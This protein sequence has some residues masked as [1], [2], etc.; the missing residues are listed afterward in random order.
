M[1][2]KAIAL[3]RFQNRSV[4][5]IWRQLAASL[6]EEGIKSHGSLGQNWLPGTYLET[7]HRHSSTGEIPKG[8]I[9]SGSS[10]SG[11]STYYVNITK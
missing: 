2:S 9:Y 5:E 10:A 6:S 1:K 8:D 11:R 4:E 7:T 3:Q